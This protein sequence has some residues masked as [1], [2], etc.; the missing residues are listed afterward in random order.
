MVTAHSKNR[1]CAEDEV[2][3]PQSGRCIPECSVCDGVVDCGDGDDM[4]ERNCWFAACPEKHRRLCGGDVGCYSPSRVCDGERNCG[5]SKVD[6][7][8]CFDSCSDYYRRY[9]FLKR[10][11]LQCLDLSGC[12][13]M[14]NVC[15]GKQD[16]S[17]GSD[18]TDCGKKTS[19]S[20]SSFRRV[21]AFDLPKIMSPCQVHVYC[22][23]GVE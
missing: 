4:D 16:C 23:R 7:H 8:N 9:E 15:D 22:A 19:F 13:H 20:S 1:L 6:E 12:V 2:I 14:K 11:V 18:E 10:D 21:T 17:D 5:Q 3:C